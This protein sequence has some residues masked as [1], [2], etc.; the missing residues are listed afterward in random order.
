M[1]S[2][3]FA[4]LRKNAFLLVVM[5]I[6]HMLLPW[7]RAIELELDHRQGSARTRRTL[8]FAS[9]LV[10]VFLLPRTKLKTSLHNITSLDVRARIEK[11]LGSRRKP[12]KLRSS[13][14]TIKDIITKSFIEPMTAAGCSKPSD[15][16]GVVCT[17]WSIPSPTGV[18]IPTRNGLS[19][20]FN[21][22]LNNCCSK[23]LFFL[24]CHTGGNGFE[25]VTRTFCESFCWVIV[26]L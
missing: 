23:E 14:H 15:R 1:G 2:G 21:E 25:S 8:F 22:L 11:T 5:A 9:C 10:L 17:M 26:A 6:R 7:R 19:F 12:R 13:P 4:A 16:P 3:I 20:S 18:I 24:A